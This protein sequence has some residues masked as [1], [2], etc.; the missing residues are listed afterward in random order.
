MARY[1]RRPQPPKSP[2]SFVSQCTPQELAKLLPA[3]NRIATSFAPADAPERVGFA[4]ALL[5]D[6]VYSLPQLR[7]AMRALVG[8]VDL[9]KAAEGR[10]DA[11]WVDAEKFPEIEEQRF[12]SRVCVCF[13]GGG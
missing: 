11:M 10:T 2:V 8:A 9:A 5:N 1:R 4:S 6:I 12:V 13:L 3:F 7:E